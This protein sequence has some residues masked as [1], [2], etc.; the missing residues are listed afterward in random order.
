MAREEKPIRWKTLLVLLAIA[1]GLGTLY[2]FTD[3]AKKPVHTDEAILA[4]KSQ[5]Y[6]QTGTFEYD[7]KDYHGPFLHHITKWV[8]D[9]RGWHPDTLTEEQ[10]RW[11]VAVCG[12]LLVMTPLLFLDVIGRTGAGVSALLIAVSPMMTYYSR[13][14]IM[15][16]PFVL[17]TALFIATMWQWAKGKKKLW[18]V[19]AGLLLGFMHATKETFVL[20]VA[21]LLL[22]VAVVKLMGLNFEINSRSYGF[23]SFTKKP[24]P[25]WAWIIFIATAALAS[26]WMFSNGFRD[27]QHV[28][29]SVTTYQSYLG[30][31]QGAGGH[32]KPWGYYISL[33]FWRRQGFL[34]SEA[35]IGGLAIIGILNAFLD[36]RR[37]DHKRAFLVCFST[38]ALVLLVIYSLIPYKTPW[39]VLA[40]DHAFALLAGLGARTVF[41]VFTE[42][43]LVKAVL[44]MLLAGGI[45]NLCQQTSLAT[46]FTSPHASPYA[47][48]ELRN[49][50]AYSH[51]STNLVELSTY[52]HQLAGKHAAGKAMPVQIIQNE[53][54]WPLPWYLRDMTHVGY[55]TTA[56]AKV[57][58][59][60][61]LVDADRVREVSDR[62][63]S[64]YE[65]SFWRLR[66]NVA[67][68]LLVEKALINR[69]ADAIT[70]PGTAAPP[71]PLPAPTAPA[72]APNPD[73]PPALPPAM[74]GTP[75]PAP[76]TAAP[77]P[78]PV[79][80]AQGM[81]VPP[82]AQLVEDDPP[83]LVGPPFPVP[84]PT[85]A[86]SPVEPAAP[87]QADPSAPAPPTT[88]SAPPPSAPVPPPIGTPV[89]AAPP[90]N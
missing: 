88:E 78:A 29:D 14:Y 80:D 48:N 25:W 6:W 27:W 64:D 68:V 73:A 21:A 2:R 56:P 4:L 52:I 33:L 66:T 67:L 53:S 30:R 69:H 24:K 51:T 61:I 89:P 41:R 40:V 28:A 18:L 7:P 8:G 34:W 42:V 65:S 47:G 11:V 39:S 19:P 84:V 57:D 82:K 87:P 79:M 45:Y 85:P 31:S 5:E 77:A 15:E 76:G 17:L 26:V 90:S 86:P 43:P 46:D 22:G 1:L 70:S 20:N 9:I 81:P 50:Y 55:Q 12:L 63:K 58:A 74:I 35:L 72:S 60:V 16:V 10:V 13:Y 75:T 3:L 71:A 44:A 37:A 38:Y 83:P 36:R 62:L 54:G 59:P 23:R 49:P 32:E